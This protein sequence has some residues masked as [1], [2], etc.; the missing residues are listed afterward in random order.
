[1]KKIILVFGLVLLSF[2]LFA[3]DFLTGG[4]FEFDLDRSSDSTV[5]S[6]THFVLDLFFGVYF[7]ENFAIGG[8]IGYYCTNFNNTALKI[9]SF[10]EYEFLKLQH[11]S[12]GIMPSLT[13]NYYPETSDPAVIGYDFDRNSIELGADL[14][15]N[16]FLTKNIQIFTS[17]LNI[18]FQHQ[19]WDKTDS[20]ERKNYTRDVFS[21]EG[22]SNL[23]VGIK[24][25]F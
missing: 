13:Y 5:D 12:F 20:E 21:I 19:W 8:I 16:L 24:F 17:F 4:I 7:F 15:I 6:Y 11:F 18:N 23:K 25:R 3:A 10:I 22:L 1:M 2:N 14:L 9:G